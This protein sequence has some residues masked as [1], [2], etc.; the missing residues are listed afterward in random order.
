MGHTRLG[1]L[2]RTRKWR[3]VVELIAVGA[4]VPQVASA[5]IKAAE[6]AFKFVSNDKG[7]NEA[8]W[9]IT[10]LGL[11]AS[12]SNPLEYLRSQGVDIPNETSLPGIVVALSEALDRHSLAEGG[13]SDLAE[14]S[15]R[16]LVDAVVQ[17]LEPKLLQMS[18]FNLKAE[19]T[20]QALTEF[21]KEKQFGKLA[22]EFF[23]RLTRECMNYFLSKTLATN[24]GEGQRFTTM[25]QMSQFDS[26]LAT[27]CREAS[28]I[29]EK[30]SEE[31]FSKHRYIE[32]KQIS[33]ESATGFASY[34]LKKMNDE[35]RIRASNDGQ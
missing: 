22:S 10:Q 32:D 8:V 29:V 16:A 12:H 13:K 18:L 20:Q 31:W 17:R 3:E 15:H 24:L 1:Q 25:N 19:H 23:S 34:A 11:A 14:L 28:A 26:A 35:L 30:F 7:Y 5:T 6:S 9:L 4:N 33:R 2:P 27:H 21:G